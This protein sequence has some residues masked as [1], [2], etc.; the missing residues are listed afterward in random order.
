M[1]NII[2]KSEI[3]PLFLKLTQ[4]EGLVMTRHV[5]A[6]IYKIYGYG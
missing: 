5:F 3:V 2:P 6:Q 4:L 1:S